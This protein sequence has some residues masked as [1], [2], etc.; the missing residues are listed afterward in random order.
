LKSHVVN[1]ACYPE[2]P[3]RKT[4][5]SLLRLHH[6]TRLQSDFHQACKPV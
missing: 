1:K 3:R 4:G 6:V 5:A 2:N